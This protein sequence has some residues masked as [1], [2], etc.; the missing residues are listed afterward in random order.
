MEDDRTETITGTLYDLNVLPSWTVLDIPDAIAQ[1]GKI[2]S[3]ERYTPVQVLLRTSSWRTA[4]LPLNGKYFIPIKKE[5]KEKENVS[6]GQTITIQ[7]TIL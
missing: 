3:V 6:A 1:L 5:I 7:L 2:M 4:I